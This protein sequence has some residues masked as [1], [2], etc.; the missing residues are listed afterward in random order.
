MYI[1]VQ[2]VRYL[3]VT[4]Q[5]RMRL[6]VQPLVSATNVIS[7]CQCVYTCACVCQ[8]D[9]WVYGVYVCLYVSAL[10]GCMSVCDVHACMLKRYMVCICDAGVCACVRDVSVLVLV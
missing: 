9:V 2:Q 7:L 5:M 10:K 6:F 1:C 3:C 4:D 8:Q